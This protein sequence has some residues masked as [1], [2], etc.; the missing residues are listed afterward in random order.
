MSAAGTIFNI[1]KFSIHDG[2]GIRTLVFFKGCPCVASGA[3]TPNHSVPNP[4]PATIRKNASA[5]DAAW[6]GAPEAF[7]P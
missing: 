6:P 5:A 2:P 3:A 7:S 4:N 1:Q